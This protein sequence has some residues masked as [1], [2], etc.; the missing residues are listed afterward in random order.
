M[1]GWT[2]QRRRWR[3]GDEQ[4]GGGGGGRIWGRTI[5]WQHC[6]VTSCLL[7]IQSTWHEWYAIEFIHDTN[8]FSDS[9]DVAK[10]LQHAAEKKNIKGLS[11]SYSTQDEIKKVIYS[12]NY[13]YFMII[14]LKIL[15]WCLEAKLFHCD[16]YIL[17]A[18]WCWTF[19]ICHP[20]FTASLR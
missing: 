14:F 7:N 11:H 19:P 17:A 12:D 4:R 2:A 20:L 5:S 9:Y 1:G 15:L 16:H 10:L 13:E 6:R 3:R 18:S 8:E